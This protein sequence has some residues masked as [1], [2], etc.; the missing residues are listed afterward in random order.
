MEVPRG[1]RDND[2][3]VDAAEEVLRLIRLDILSR[4]EDAVLVLEAGA[5]GLA[6]KDD[7]QQ[8]QRP[9]G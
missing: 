7:Q 5:D 2:G 1:D 6:S 8:L 4:V 9:K 3:A